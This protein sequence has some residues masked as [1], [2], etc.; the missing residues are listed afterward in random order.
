MRL[1]PAKAFEYALVP[2]GDDG[3]RVRGII[4]HCGAYGCNNVATVPVNTQSN[5]T[6]NDDEI[7]FKFI[8]RKLE[9]MGW[10]IGHVRYQHRCPKCLS[11]VKFDNKV[12]AKKNG[13]QPMKV[14]ENTRV[15]SREDRRIIFDK[16]NQ[17]YVDDAVGYGAGWT[18]EKVATDLGVPRAWVRVIREE[19]F[20]DE[21]ANEDIRKKLNEATALL[22]EMKQI[23]PDVR[24]WLALLDKTEKQLAE[25]QKVF[26]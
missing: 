16:L 19:N 22:A 23:E 11:I 13:A 8:S 1:N 6:G 14:V 15:M 9:R 25:I 21:V 18:D 20:G 7:E 5:S 12:E 26:K 4:A 10:Q 2:H 24:Q 17:V 3:R